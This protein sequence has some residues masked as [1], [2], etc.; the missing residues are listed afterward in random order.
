VSSADSRLRVATGKWAWVAF[1]VLS[2]LTISG[3]LLLPRDSLAQAVVYFALEVVAALA[4][5]FAMALHRRWSLPF[6]LLAGNL[7]L[8]AVGDTIWDVYSFLLHQDAPYPSVADVAF[9]AGYPLLFI[10]MLVIVRGRGRPRLG[11]LLDGAIIGGGFALLLW[12]FLIHPAVGNGAPLLSGL[13]SAM[14]PAMD[15]LILLGLTQ[16]AFSKGT[17]NASYNLFFAG[18]LILLTADVVYSYLV[19]SGAYVPGSLL[20]AGWMTVF[21]CW[22]IAAL[23]PSMRGLADIQRAPTHKFSLWRLASLTAALL[24]VPILLETDPSVLD[25][26][27]LAGGAAFLT[28]AALARIALLW[29]Q[30]EV[31]E[32]RLSDSERR[33][34]QLFKESEEHNEELRELDTLKDELLALVSHE[35]RT[36]LT[37]IRG[38]LEL[39][40]EDT[41]QTLSADHR[42]FLDVV[43]RN[44]NRLLR[45]VNDLLLLAR[46]QAGRLEVETRP[47][48]LN[49]I[50][51]E[52]V[53]TA[54]PASERGMLTLSLHTRDRIIATIDPER[55]AQVIDNLLSNAIKFT[56]PGGSI[57]VSVSEEGKSAVIEIAD[58]GMGISA[59]EQS[60]LF[61]RFFRTRSAT[62]A[63]I[64][65]TG[66]GLAISKAIV[67]GHGGEIG[68]RSEEGLGTTFRVELPL[69]ATALVEQAEGL[70]R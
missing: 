61:T 31:V 43:D 67:E 56:P 49:S 48:D 13:V 23:H 11:D 28:L 54:R 12:V 44:S 51:A 34:R 26:R 30:R 53:A 4:C 55:V 24:V 27:I 41:S 37:S 22:G 15:G 21:A 65:G 45:L 1:S 59:A 50:A 66:L 8:W 7:V 60:Q 14:Y 20:D 52:S 46:V 62:V 68:V 33:L 69:G 57:D 70:A 10:A 63:G 6:W 35:L 36:P 16:L 3:Y 58:T 42:E 29:R 64:Q 2:A 17:R 38:Y 40:L 9:T 39:V 47:F 18:F 32:R 19:T 25:R 5:V